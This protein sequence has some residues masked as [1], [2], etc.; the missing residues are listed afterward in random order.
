MAK[1]I[2]KK[3]ST[4]VLNSAKTH[5]VRYDAEDAENC[6]A[7][8]IYVSKDAFEGAGSMPQKITVSIEVAE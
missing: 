3:S 7:S 2:V 6:V 1:T 5:S 8:S 4:F